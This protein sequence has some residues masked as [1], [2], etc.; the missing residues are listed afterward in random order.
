MR[1]SV[2][3]LMCTALGAGILALPK[4]LNDVGFVVGVLFISFAGFNALL[5]M[6][7]LIYASFKTGITNYSDLIEDRFGKVKLFPLLHPT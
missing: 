7:L 4:I 3:A 5:S 2:F 6:Y 1:G